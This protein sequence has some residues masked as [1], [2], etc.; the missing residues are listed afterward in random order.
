M[1]SG[2]VLK[3]EIDEN[4]NIR[5]VTE[6]TLT[7][8]SKK[9][10]NTRYNYVNF[11]REA[12]QKDVDTHCETI[13]KRVWGLKKHQELIGQV[14]VDDLSKDLSSCDIVTKHAVLDKDGKIVTPEVKITIDDK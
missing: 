11:S 3:S 6:Y 2:K 10:G 7:D 9:I 12:V 13:M 14:K 5:V 1:I 4:G 8:G